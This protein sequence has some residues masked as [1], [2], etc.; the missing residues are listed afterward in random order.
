MLMTAFSGQNKKFTAEQSFPGGPEL[1]V[2]PL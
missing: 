1:R 2:D